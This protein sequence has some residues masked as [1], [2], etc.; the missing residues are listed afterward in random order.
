[1]LLLSLLLPWCP[2]PCYGAYYNLRQFCPWHHP[3]KGTTWLVRNVLARASRWNES[4][5]GGQHLRKWGEN[6]CCQV[7]GFV[8]SGTFCV[9]YARIR[10]IELLT[11]HVSKLQI[12]A[13]NSLSGTINVSVILQSAKC[14]PGA[15]PVVSLRWFSQWGVYKFFLDWAESKTKKQ[16]LQLLWEKDSSS[17]LWHDVGESPCT[18]MAFSDYV[19]LGFLHI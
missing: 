15:G 3:V 12:L 6:R 14:W 9:Q 5:N 10:P 19:R 13:S 8:L 7:S 16:S 17:T 1:M 18:G 4:Y 11:T 2:F